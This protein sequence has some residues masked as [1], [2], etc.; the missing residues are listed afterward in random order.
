MNQIFTISDYNVLHSLVFR[1]D[2]PGYKPTVKEIPAG[3][4]KVDADKRY[5][6]V[7]SRYFADDWQRAALM[8]YLEKA[9][10]LAA[11]V[12]ED[13]KIPAQYR[14]DIHYGAL[15][16][17]D[18]PAGA[19]SHRH[20]DFDLFTLMMFRDQPQYF[21]S[22]DVEAGDTIERI[23]YFNPQAHLGLLGQEIGLGKATPHQ[24][25]PAPDRQRSI[26]YFAI[27]DHDATL[28]SGQTVREWL[29]AIMTRTRTEFKAYESE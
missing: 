17:L 24:V 25:L 7:A 27:P 4:G 29:N 22:D 1:S 13:A 18:Y 8:P 9:H 16:V 3:D 28:P 10:R 19:V 12:A 14:P 23:R 6:H 21:S 26:V 20:E 2:Y 15:R 11:M 5:A